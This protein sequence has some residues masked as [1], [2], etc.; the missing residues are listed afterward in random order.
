MVEKEPSIREAAL[1]QEPSVRELGTKVL[2]ELKTFLKSHEG[3]IASNIA[4]FGI[5]YRVF[6]VMVGREPKINNA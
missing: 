3:D 6:M 5:L 4:D 1:K 2:E